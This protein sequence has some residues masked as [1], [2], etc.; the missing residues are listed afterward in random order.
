MARGRLTAGPREAVAAAHED[1]AHVLGLQ[2]RAHSVDRGPEDLLEQRVARRGEGGDVVHGLGLRH[3]AHADDG[4]GRAGRGRQG[5][6]AEANAL[7]HLGARAPLEAV[8]ADGGR[9]RAVTAVD[10]RRFRVKAD[11]LVLDDRVLAEAELQVREV[12]RLQAGDVDLEPAGELDA[13]VD[14]QLPGAGDGDVRAGGRAD[15]R[16]RV[17]E[18]GCGRAGRRPAGDRRDGVGLHVRVVDG[19]Q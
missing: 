19:G 5:H 6:E 7:V 2:S 1:A 11:D 4:K 8:G 10:G 12:R 9:A 14:Y 3:G 13:E 17:E 16:G 18:G 15:R